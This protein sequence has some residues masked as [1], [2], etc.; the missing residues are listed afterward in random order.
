MPCVVGPWRAGVAGDAVGQAHVAHRPEWQFRNGR[1][2]QRNSVRAIGFHS[3]C[4]DGP[5]R[6]LDFARIHFGRLVVTARRHDNEPKH[7]R[8]V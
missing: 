6:T 1:G 7:A 2:G 3:R 5:K 8:R 4:G